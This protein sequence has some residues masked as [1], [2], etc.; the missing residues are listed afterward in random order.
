MTKKQE[1]EKSTSNIYTAMLEVYGEVGYVQKSG[2]VSTN[3]KDGNNNW[4]KQ[5]MYKYAGEA[6]LISALRPAMVRAGIIVYPRKI[7]EIQ[8]ND[9]I[10]EN[11]YGKATRNNRT[12][13]HTVFRFTHA[14][15]QSHID[16]P[17]IGAG[18]DTGDKDACGS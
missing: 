10:T 4:K 13:T 12:V 8:C 6:D 5:L 3:K 1:E 17:A 16:V 14:A 15:S 7:K 18:I 11:S 2:E 9:Y